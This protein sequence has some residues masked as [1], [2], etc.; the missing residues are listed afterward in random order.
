MAKNY[1]DYF[2]DQFQDDLKDGLKLFHTTK[3]E[4]EFVNQSV[5][6]RKRMYLQQY[7]DFKN[8]KTGEVISSTYGEVLE[9]IKKSQKLE[10]LKNV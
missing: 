6:N 1:N 5:Y 10:E 4:Y 8:L 9:M 2:S 7:C 3:G